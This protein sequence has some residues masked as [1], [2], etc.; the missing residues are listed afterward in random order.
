[1]CFTV[2]VTIHSSVTTVPPAQSPAQEGS[3]MGSDISMLSLKPPI[4]LFSVSSFIA[5]NAF[6]GN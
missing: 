5:F 3:F 2:I 4:Q 6:S 1:M